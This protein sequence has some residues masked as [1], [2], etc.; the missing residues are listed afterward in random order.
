[1][2][3]G[4]IDDS[5]IF[6]R[7]LARLADREN[8]LETVLHIESGEALPALVAAAPE[9]VFLDLNLGAASGL[10]LLPRLRAELPGAAVILLTAQY[11]VDVAEAALAAGARAC[12]AK[13][14]LV[15]LLR[16]LARDGVDALTSPGPE[17]GRVRSS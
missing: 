15:P 7:T 9:L 10:D 3:I 4:I 2:R 5:E 12:F 11:T 8:G 1:M 13:E 6:A 14:H 17:V 16:A